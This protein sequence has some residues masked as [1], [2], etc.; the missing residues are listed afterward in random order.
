VTATTRPDRIETEPKATSLNSD[1][2]TRP[3][4]PAPR[5]LDGEQLIGS[6][7]CVLI[8]HRG[9]TYRLCRTRAGKLILTK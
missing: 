2:G 8:A 7:G 1:I 5:T 3:S 9:Q 6:S 4:R